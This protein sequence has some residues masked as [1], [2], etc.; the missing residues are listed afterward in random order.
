MAK[1]AYMENPFLNLDINC[2]SMAGYYI[3]IVTESTY[4][5]DIQ[6]QTLPSANRK[7]DLGPNHDLVPNY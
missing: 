7:T 5:C 4:C 2:H 1:R 3:D 6:I